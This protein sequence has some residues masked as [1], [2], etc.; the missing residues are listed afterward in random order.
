MTSKPGLQSCTQH[1]LRVPHSHQKVCR[2][3]LLSSLSRTAWVGFTG[4]GSF[5]LSPSHICDG[6]PLPWANTT[7]PPHQGPDCSAF[8]K[9]CDLQRMRIE[10]F[11]LKISAA[12]SLNHRLVCS[13]AALERERNKLFGTLRA[14]ISAAWRKPEGARG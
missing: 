12:G 6:S 1:H 3:L 2:S 13:A 4:R 9:A 11:F 7:R 5:L 10:S 14:V 8:L